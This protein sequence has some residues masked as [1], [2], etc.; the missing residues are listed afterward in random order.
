[1]LPSCL[2]AHTTP[3]H[4]NGDRAP[5]NSPSLPADTRDRAALGRGAVLGVHAR[6]RNERRKKGKMTESAR[7]NGENKE[8]LERSV[9]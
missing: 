6:T 5:C 8:P 2:E 3:S 4:E 7:R 9:K 1:M